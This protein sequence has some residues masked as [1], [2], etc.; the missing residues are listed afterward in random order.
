MSCGT[1]ILF[2]KIVL[3]I[4]VKNEFRIRRIACVTQYDISYALIAMISFGKK[5][6][7]A[8]KNTRQMTSVAN[9]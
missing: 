5:I 4:S 8:S 1:A 6:N 9:N 7:A 2:H 3:K